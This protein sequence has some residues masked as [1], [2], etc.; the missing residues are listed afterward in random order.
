MDSKKLGAWSLA[1]L[2]LAASLSAFLFFRGDSSAAAEQQIREALHR[3]PH[4]F[5]MRNTP[6]VCDLFASDLVASYPGMKDKNYQ[7]MCSNFSLILSNLDKLYFYEEPEIQQILV[8][9][10]LAVVRLIW[11]LNVKEK[12]QKEATI[13]EKGMDVFRRQPDGN[14]KISV[15]YAYELLSST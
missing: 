1:V 12:G 6:A 13:K 3:W 15:S 4:D 10:D 2:I 14:W 11:T 9:G 8:K 5:N 7:E